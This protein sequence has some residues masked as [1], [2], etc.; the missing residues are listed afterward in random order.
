ML[1][2]KYTFGLCHK[3]GELYLEVTSHISKQDGH[4]E[5]SEWDLSLD[6]LN[7]VE[8]PLPLPS[9]LN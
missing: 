1:K 2:L 5:I 6:Q 7:N 9:P 4:P 8:L 3:L